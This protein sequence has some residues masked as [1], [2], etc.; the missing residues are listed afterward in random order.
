VS[1]KI[2]R[3]VV[4][5]DGSDNARHAVEWAAWLARNIGAEV[6]A[7]HARGLVERL[8]G[9]GDGHPDPAW[10]APLQRA[11][12]RHRET[13]RAGNPVSVLLDA[14]DEEGAGLLVVGSRGVGGYPELLLGSTSTQVVQRATCPVVVVPAASPAAP[15]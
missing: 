13:E 12:V 15:G 10:C 14:V 5:I 3:I 8:D 11:G 2:D 4:G 9:P 7:V 6:V 1:A